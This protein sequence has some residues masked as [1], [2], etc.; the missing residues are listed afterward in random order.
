MLQRA[1]PIIREDISS[2]IA[3]EEYSQR[4]LL[5]AREKFWQYRILMNPR[6]TLRGQWFPRSL[7]RKLR[8]FWD[9]CKA[10]KRPV[11]LLGDDHRIHPDNEREGESDEAGL[12]CR[13]D[14]VLELRLRICAGNL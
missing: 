1:T 12:V 11:M 10:G 8:G 4:D 9:D 2:P 6:F 7:A 13:I 5:E 14:P 3:V